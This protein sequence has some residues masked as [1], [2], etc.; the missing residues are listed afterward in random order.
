MGTSMAVHVVPLHL[1]PSLQL[2]E[3]A[4]LTAV[5]AAA[6]AVGTLFECV[7][8]LRAGHVWNHTGLACEQQVSWAAGV[9]TSS[10]AVRAV[11]LHL[12]PSLEGSRG[13]WDASCAD[14]GV[15]PPLLLLGKRQGF[16]YTFDSFGSQG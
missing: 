14:L 2:L 9:G 3:P 11:P 6:L 15:G 5:V 13:M 12:A 10:S 8:V 7:P 1:A 16:A 4:V